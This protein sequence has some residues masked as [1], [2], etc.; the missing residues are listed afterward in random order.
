MCDTEISEPTLSEE[1]KNIILSI[2]GFL[3]QGVEM[4]AD[5]HFI[6]LSDAVRH[7]LG[8]GIAAE[9]LAMLTAAAAD[10]AV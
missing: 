7:L 10:N 4:Y 1:Y 5:R 8:A 6:P 2:P 9:A 3:Y